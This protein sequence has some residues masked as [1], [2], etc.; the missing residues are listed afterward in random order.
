MS[1]EII[2]LVEKLDPVLRH[3]TRFNIVTVLIV[4]G[5]KTMGE[6]A[7]I[8]DLKWGP[9]STHIDRLKREGYI[10]LRK[11]IFTSGPRTLVIL[12]RKGFEKY[13]EYVKSLEKVLEKLKEIKLNRQDIEELRKIRKDLLLI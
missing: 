13:N 1:R 11:A 10:E 8:L 2:E 12:T 7:R 6:I 5:P 4:S 9:L 3:P